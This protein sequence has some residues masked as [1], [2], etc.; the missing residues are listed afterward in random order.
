VRAAKQTLTLAL[1]LS[2]RLA[3]AADPSQPLT[4]LP[5]TPSLNLT[6]MDRAVDPCVDFYAYSCGGWQRSNPI[7]ADQSRWS[8][9]SKVYNDNLAFLW[10]I[11]EAAAKD[12][13]TPDEKR[14]GAYYAS[15]VDEATI[16]GRGLAPIQKDLDA[17]AAVSSTRQL[18]ALLAAL[19]QRT[20]GN[21][22]LFRFA[23]SQDYGDATSVI[24]EIAAGGLGLPDRDYYVATDEDSKTK[25][26]LYRQHVAAMLRLAGDSAD[27]SFAA[28]DQILALETRLAEASLTRVERR[29]PYKTYNKKTRQELLALTPRFDWPTYLAGLGLAELTSVNVAQPAFLRRVDEL[30]GSVPLG[31]WKTYLRWQLINTQAERLPR[32]FADLDFGFYGKGLRGTQSRAPRWKECVQDVDDQLGEAL[33]KVFVE[34]T[35][36][37]AT[38]GDTTHMVDLIR[39]AM[40]SRVDGLDW[41]S[42]ATKAQALRKLGAMANKIGYPEAWRDY[43]SIQIGRDD[44]Y[45]NAER[46]IA[47]EYRRQL[48]KIGRAVDRGEW[49]MTPPTVNAYYDPQMND[50]NFPAGI[51]QPPLYDPKSDDAPNYG[52]TGSTIGHELTHGFDDEGRQ[53]DAQ[54]NLKDWWT[55]ADAAAFE[56]RVSCVADQYATYTIVDDIKINSRLTLGEDVADL[57]GTILAYEAWRLQTQAQRLRPIDGLTPDQRFFVG[58]AQWAC[59]SDRPEALR[60]GARTNPHSPG[61]YRINGV[62]VNMPE[63]AAAFSC[64]PGQPMV[65]KASEICRI[66]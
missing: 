18:P 35:F 34:R 50:I 36:S 19:H 11:L 51:L 43:S 20:R 57:G 5:Y 29:D 12:P 39:Q 46:S 45:G 4:A 55:P 41:M 44:Y 16:D 62:V 60:V 6:A 26:E 21:S 10:G 22:L 23:S 30:L 66:W 49:G 17:I 37:P 32:A 48:S 59:G 63:F 8:V 24:G 61:Q 3:F 13:K 15:C 14:I 33:G 58:F 9:Y 42:A 65:K 54:G 1:A 56:K 38:K 53:F 52:N 64:K 27:T 25:R 28:A 47:F 31:T 2:G 7:P 40:K